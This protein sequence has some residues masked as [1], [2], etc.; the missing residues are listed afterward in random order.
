MATS[1]IAAIAEQVTSDAEFRAWCQSIHDGMAAVGLVQTA[2]TGQ[3]N[4]STVA[5]PGASTTK[6]GY[7]IW[8]FPTSDPLQATRPLY[9]KISYGTG[10]LSTSRPGIWFR[11]GGGSNGSGTLTNNPPYEQRLDGV[12]TTGA[13]T[14]DHWFSYGDEGRFAMI[15]HASSSTSGQPVMVC[16]ERDRDSSGAAT[17][18][19][20]YFHG[21][22]DADG[23]FGGFQPGTTET[24]ATLTSG[25]ANGFSNVR[26][27]LG[28]FANATADLDPSGDKA[29][30]VSMPQSRGRA[31]QPMLGHVAVYQ[32]D[33]SVS[34]TFACTR[35]GVSRTYKVARD[36]TQWN[37]GG[38]NIYPAILWE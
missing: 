4:L 7:E 33:F 37:S 19:G 34:G 8:K 22:A 32:G 1:V 2:D 23:S 30:L 26:F 38:G 5:R 13:S 9:I 6:A 36:I 10:S 27:A 24:Y 3:I 17:T 29:V 20:A 12:K 18:G 35:Y 16:V 14:S 28:A 31:R 21:A 11:I 25:N 15:L